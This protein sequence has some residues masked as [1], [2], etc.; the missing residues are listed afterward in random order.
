MRAILT[1]GAGG[2]E[3]LDWGEAPEPTLGLEDVRIRVVATAVNRADLMQRMG[4]YPPPPGA[5]PI[6]GLECSGEVVEVGDAVPGGRA[7]GDRVMAL[8]AG[9][10]YAEQVVVHHGSVMDVPESLDL[11]TAAGT[12]EVFLTV[13]LN[14]FRLAAFPAGGALLVHG[15]ASGIGTAAIALVREAGGR[16]LVTAGSPEKCERCLELGA[17]A[18]IDYRREDFAERVA[19][20]TSGRGVDVVLDSIGGPYLAGNLASLAVGGRL[21]LIGLMGGGSAELDL[22]SLLLRRLQ[23]IGSTLRGRSVAEKADLVAA[24]VERFGPAIEAGRVAP[25]V[26]RVLPIEEAGQAHRVLEES[27]HV[28][29]VLLRVG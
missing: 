19:A 25:V 28:G 13:F 15:G 23:I 1:R 18:A 5:S 11:V 10:G 2:P 21:V 6:L 9:G 4:F 22:G 14:V 17:D 16:C 8:L 20:L 12:P 27:S 29:K 7:P 26:D 24:F 3:V